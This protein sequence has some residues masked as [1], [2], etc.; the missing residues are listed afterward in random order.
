[1][2]SSEQL[3]DPASM[4]KRRTDSQSCPVTLTLMCTPLRI[5]LQE[6]VT[7][8]LHCSDG[9]ND[10]SSEHAKLKI[11]YSTVRQAKDVRQESCQGWWETGQHSERD[12]T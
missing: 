10:L 9:G 6:A 8:T 3:T 2:P 4:W 1:M 11:T 5:T 12:D 7:Q